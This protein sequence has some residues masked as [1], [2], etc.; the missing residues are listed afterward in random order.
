MVPAAGGGVESPSLTAAPH[1]A[2]QAARRSLESSAFWEDV[3]G[4]EGAAET[5]RE[6]DA[7]ASAIARSSLRYF[8]LAHNRTRDYTADFERMVAAKGNTAVSLMYAVA[9][10][11]VRASTRKPVW[12][13]HFPDPPH[14]L[15][16]RGR[17]QAILRKAT[18]EGTGTRDLA[19]MW[20]EGNA[21]GPWPEAGPEGSEGIERIEG[22]GGLDDASRAL[23]LTLTQY[24][25]AK[26][27]ALRQ[28]SPHV[29]TEH[30]YATA[31]SFHAFYGACPVL[32]SGPHER[33]RLWLCAATAHVLQHGMDLVGVKVVDRM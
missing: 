20:L 33:F 30:L 19:A 23:V 8:E 1:P 18:Q 22:N 5:G 29:L 31:A 14:S 21:P 17:D 11:K 15:C 25:D 2:P 6:K 3:V 9:R 32:G 16:V 26:D 24:P 28:L 7:V 12:W 10:I 4:R 13:R 27:Q